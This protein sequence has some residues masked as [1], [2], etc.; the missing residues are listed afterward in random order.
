MLRPCVLL[1]LAAM[2]SACVTPPK[3]LYAWGSY[4]QLIYTSY[5]TPGAGD[6]QSQVD[7]LEK[8]FQ[9]ARGSNQR[10]PPGWHAHLGY[11]YFQ[12]GK[13][14]QAR[15]E[16]M[17]EKAEFPESAAFMDRLIARIKKS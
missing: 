10:L 16:F 9:V 4:E 17:T 14:D 11:L 8:D 5:S 12:L 6:A 15:Q 3:M 7:T 2:L 13:A 1:A